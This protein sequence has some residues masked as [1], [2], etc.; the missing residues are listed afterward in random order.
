V[1]RWPLLILRALWSRFNGP[2]RARLTQPIVE[3]AELRA[4]LVRFIERAERV[5]NGG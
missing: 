2:D 5:M 4:R 3:P 1:A